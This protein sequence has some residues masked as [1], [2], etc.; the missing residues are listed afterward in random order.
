M[1]TPKAWKELAQGCQRSHPHEEMNYLCML[2]TEI[3]QLK[4][5]RAFSK[6]R[7]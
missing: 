5:R 4:G 1:F 6:R 7:F 2:K 3:A